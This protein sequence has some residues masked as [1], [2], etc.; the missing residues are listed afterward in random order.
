MKTE[1]SIRIV[2]MDPEAG[3]TGHLVLVPLKDLT[4]FSISEAVVTW[5]RILKNAEDFVFSD[6]I[7]EDSDPWFGFGVT[8]EDRVLDE[9]G[10]FSQILGSDSLIETSVSEYIEALIQFNEENDD[11]GLATHEELET[12]TYAILWLL[13]RSLKYL[14]L[15]IRYLNSLDLDHTVAQLDVLFQLAKQYSPAELGSL[16]KFAKEKDAQLL[17]DWLEAN[18]VWTEQ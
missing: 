11:E 10:L 13:Q 2:E 12:G 14:P 6:P 5:T 9:Q 16:K 15:Y 1:F 8:I 3:F 7:F 17:N 4:P 18:R